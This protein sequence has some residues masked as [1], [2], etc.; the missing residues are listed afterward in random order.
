MFGVAKFFVLSIQVG[1]SR[2]IEMTV[3]AV[4]SHVYELFSLR[5]VSTFCF[6][7]IEVLMHDMF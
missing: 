4:H 6:M 1:P 7:N 3:K 2:L 5:G